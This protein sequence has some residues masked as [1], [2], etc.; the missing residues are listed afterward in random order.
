MKNKFKIVLASLLFIGLWSCTDESDLQ[1]IA[2]AGSEFSVITPDGSTTVIIDEKH[3]S[4]PA[5][6]VTWS[7]AQ[8]TATTSI[9]YR[10]EIA[11]NDTAF[12]APVIVGTVTNATNLTLSMEELNSYA[13]LA[14]LEPF[15][16]GAIDIRVISYVGVAGQEEQISKNFQTISVTCFS[17]Y[18]YQEYYLVGD[19]T[20]AGWNN[21]NNNQVLF[22]DATDGK[23]FTLTT[24]FKA[25]AFKLLEKKGQWQPQ[26]GQVGGVLAGNPGTQSGDPDSFSIATA[27]YY[28]FTLNMND[29]SYTL[30]PYT[31]S[32]TAYTTIGIIGS[33]TPGGWDAD[34]DMVKT[35]KHIWYISSIDLKKGE[36]KFRA[37]NDW[38]TNWGGSTKLSGIGTNGGANIPVDG[39]KYNVWFNDLDG[40]YMFIPIK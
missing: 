37:E 14:G 31:G 39:G 6:T 25:G 29:K 21:D 15:V 7:A 19:A 36:G 40:A 27:G 2:P 35:D 5:V 38:G 8:Y 18:P 32:T 26:W 20:D 4:N 22:R 11:K 10:V 12:L 23:K 13:T 16:A 33:A 3:L 34:T 17:S 9:N 1:Q 24:Y 30:K 28:T